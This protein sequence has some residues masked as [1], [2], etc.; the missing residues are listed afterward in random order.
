[1]NLYRAVGRKEARLK[2][3]GAT[4]YRVRYG[5]AYGSRP[6]PPQVIGR[7]RPQMSRRGAERWLLRKIRTSPSWP[8]RDRKGLRLRRGAF[9][10]GCSGSYSGRALAASRKFGLL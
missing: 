6:P 8:R 7:H 10:H 2:G 9:S 1:M 5:E 4:A 3:V